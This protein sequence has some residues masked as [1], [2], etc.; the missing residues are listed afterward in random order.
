MR[1]DSLADFTPREIA[2]HAI[3]RRV[4]VGGSGPAVIVL[5]EMP[6]LS[7]QV[8]R[9]A[10]WLRDA[11]FTIWMPSLFGVDGAEGSPE[12]GAQV[13]KRACIA[14]EFRSLA[15]QGSSPITAWLRGLARLAHGECG[16]RGVGAVGMCFTGNFALSMMLEPAMLAPVLCQPALP[17]DDSAAVESPPGEL[18]QI[19]DR[20]ER[21]D[22]TV[23]A[24]RF[25]GDP[26]CRAA[27]FA[28]Y[29]AA[30]GPRF[31]GR[32]LPDFAA[33]TAP[34]PFFRAHVPAP[35]SVVTAHLVDRAGAPTRDAVDQIIAF[36][37]HRL[38]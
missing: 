14:A 7:P 23:Q 29:A 20:L 5:P 19:R 3:T 8:V 17:L 9:F 6:G 33:N 2:C 16:G 11:G 38:A 13:F 32:V 22:L 26:F 30:F 1:N 21:E 37:Q 31:D 34:P 15:G 28:A 12:D 35:H 18:A 36:L 25:A 10:R 27:R 4:H 24:W